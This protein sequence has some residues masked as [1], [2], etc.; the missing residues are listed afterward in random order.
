MYLGID[1]HCSWSRQPLSME[2]ICDTG[3]GTGPDPRLGH[4]LHTLRGLGYGQF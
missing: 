4:E 2:V 1:Q 3:K